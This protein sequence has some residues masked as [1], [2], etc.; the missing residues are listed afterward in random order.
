MTVAGL[1]STRSAIGAFANSAAVFPAET[2]GGE[3][4]HFVNGFGEGEPVFFADVQ[5]KDAG[6]CAGAAR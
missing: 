3:A 4:G 5:A 1:K 2:L 6:K